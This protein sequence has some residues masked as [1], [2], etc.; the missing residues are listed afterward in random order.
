[1]DG[2]LTLVIDNDQTVANDF[3]K[4]FGASDHYVKRLV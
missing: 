2:C 1:M 4:F 3:R